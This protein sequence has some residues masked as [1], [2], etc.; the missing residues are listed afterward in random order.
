[1]KEALEVITFFNCLCQP[2]HMKSKY[3]IDG[4]HTFV[5]QHNYTRELI[6]SFKVFFGWYAS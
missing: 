1:M 2:K 3:L 5:G 4:Q 6:A